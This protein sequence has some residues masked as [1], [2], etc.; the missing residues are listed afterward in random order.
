MMLVLKRLAVV[1]GT[2]SAILPG[3]RLGW[4][5]DS[6]HRGRS[7]CNNQPR[8][9]WGHCL[10]SRLSAHHHHPRHPFVLGLLIF[11][12]CVQCDGKPGSLAAHTQHV[13]RNRVDDHPVVILVVIAV[14]SFRLMSSV[15][16]PGCRPHCESDRQA[17]VLELQYPDNGR[18]SSIFP[19]EDKRSKQG[20]LRL[21]LSIMRWS[22][23]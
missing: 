9:S 11:V 3:G 10:V 12:A 1:A 6:P 15:N 4:G 23:R 8:R 2:V 16:I 18:S 22:Y 17:V 19:V 20:Q 13:D 14:P 5:S 21:S 7:G